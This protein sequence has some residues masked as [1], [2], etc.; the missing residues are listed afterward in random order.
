MGEIN[1]VQPEEM[2]AA[3]F[4]QFKDLI[5][6]E[7]GISLADSKITLLSNRIRKRLKMLGI[8]T[9]H[10][11]L[12]Y[13]RKAEDRE[14]E[15]VHMLDAI[16]TNVSSFFRNPKQFTA[17][18]EKV[19]PSLLASHSKRKSLRLL[20]AGCA[21]GEEPYT[22]SMVLCE[23]FLKELLGWSV[24]ID[25]VDLCT[26]ALKKA[27]IGIY[28]TEKLYEDVE[29]R[30]MNKYFKKLDA[31]T[32]QVVN[33]VKK[34]VQ[35]RKFNLKSDEFTSAYDVIFCRNVV[36][37]FDD[38]TKEKV[39]QKFYNAMAEGAYFLVGPT[40]GILNDTRFRYVSPG[41]Y[42]KNAKGEG[43]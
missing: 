11:Y 8:E 4:R 35:F 32:Y 20:S 36:I 37:Y 30:F 13:L 24:V 2:S 19:M 28:K 18:C 25:A 10:K 26:E 12:E 9:F 33:E 31:E 14:A 1:P 17:F 40:E 23:H 43:I 39:Y 22:I 38:E 5:Y 41:I 16:T 21:T 3:V 34:S 29:A 15:I 6:Q 42:L 27:E 7:A